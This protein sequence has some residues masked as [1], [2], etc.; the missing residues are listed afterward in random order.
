MYK[1]KSAR[2]CINYTVHIKYA[3]GA[4][5]RLFKLQVSMLVT[6]LYGLRT[7]LTGWSVN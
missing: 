7:V 5:G 4:R 6:R 1:E 2:Y 3:V